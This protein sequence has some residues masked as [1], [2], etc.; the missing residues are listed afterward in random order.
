[1][2][3]RVVVPQALPAVVSVVLFS[4]LTSFDEVMI[5]LFLSGIRAET[6]A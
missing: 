2:F 5:S 1:V 6:P 3:R 4:F